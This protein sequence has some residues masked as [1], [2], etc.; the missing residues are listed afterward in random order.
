[1]N[2]GYFG[3]S[4]HNNSLLPCKILSRQEKCWSWVRQPDLLLVLQPAQLRKV[5]GWKQEATL[6]WE[7]RRQ[8]LADL[9]HSLERRRFPGAPGRDVS[10]R[11]PS[12]YY[13]LLLFHRGAGWEGSG[14]E[15]SGVHSQSSQWKGSGLNPVNEKM[16][17]GA[18]VRGMAS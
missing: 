2:S 17:T 10:R 13:S 16:V 7:V 14:S 12:H 3:N 5:D 6:S 9:T 18:T 11:Q 8:P 15:G 1:M 4:V